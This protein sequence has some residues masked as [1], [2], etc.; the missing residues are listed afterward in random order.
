M[1]L[2]GILIALFDAFIVKGLVMILAAWM[3]VKFYRAAFKPQSERPWLVVPEAQ[4][5]E[6]RLLWW[7][8]LVFLLSEVTCGL[9]IYA[10]NKTCPPLSVAHS[11]ISGVGTGLFALAIYAYLDK[12]LLRFGGI[13]CLV[14]RVC[15]GCPVQAGEACRFTPAIILLAV[16]LILAV[17][18]PLYVPT[19]PVY[20][21]LSR[22]ALPFE[23]LNSWFDTDAE[24]WLMEHISDYQPHGRGYFLPP[25]MLITEFKLLPGLALLLSLAG[26]VLAKRRKEAL[27]LRVLAFAFGMLAYTYLELALYPATEDALMGSLGHEVVELWFLIIVLEFLRR[28]FRP[29]APAQPEPAQ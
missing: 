14:N 12:A 17:I 7:S 21:D 10:V 26:V 4:L 22:Y 11:F 18:P 23:S 19:D 28:S 20:A 5:P 13:G 3:V 25:V 27:A 16:F 15:R 1:D 6:A 8:L 2:G 9:E 24:P 29:K